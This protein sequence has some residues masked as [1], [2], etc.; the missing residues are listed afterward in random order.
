MDDLFNNIP[1]DEG[2]VNVPQPESQP[3]EDIA[4]DTEQPT[5]VENRSDSFDPY[6]DIIEEL[7]LINK[8]SH[9]EEEADEK[10]KPLLRNEKTKI[11]RLIVII[12]LCISLA[13]TA[14]AMGITMIKSDVSVPNSS[15]NP[16]VS[17]IDGASPNLQE[18]PIVFEEYSGSGSMTPPQIYDSVKNS[19]VGIL[20]YLNSELIGEGSGIIVGEDDAHQY[21]YII[22]AAHVISNSGVTV[23]V[24]F[25]DETETTATIIGLDDKT[26]IGVIRVEK[27]GLKAAV[28]GNSDKLVVGQAVYAIGNP[29]GTEFFGSFTSGIISAIDRPIPTTS[30]T[31]DLPCI[32]HTAAINPGNSGG[33]LVNEFGQVIGLNSSKIASTEY[34]GMG[35]AVP[36]N[37]IIE[38][39]E[40]ILANGY[41]KGRPMLGITY[42]SVKGDEF[43]NDVA[44]KNDLPDGSI[45]IASIA[46]SSDLKGKA[47]IGDII[48][49]ANGN[50]LDT[51]DV[52]LD[53]IKD[54]TI[55]TEFTLTLCRVTEDGKITKTF[56]ITVVLVED[57]GDNKVPEPQS[58][59]DSLEDYI[60]GDDN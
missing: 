57:I 49:A 52:L 53:I 19:N 37:T 5:E 12:L 9:K 46:E 8:Q 42:M 11:G 60:F 31:Y 29:G 20:V 7:N 51:T 17:G 13:F 27:T 35:F 16:N 25:S 33:A 23:Q 50:D 22:T 40:N 10:K 6:G 26:D 36:S 43:Y 47:E 34:E 54:A 21:T 44:I 58:Q 45:V 56:D 4:M 38:I 59:S 2:E 41:V 39:Y 55:G 3:V 15:T 30:S 14:L 28:F 18:S 24:Q 48:I 1:N 32:Q